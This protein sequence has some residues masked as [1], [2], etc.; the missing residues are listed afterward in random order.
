MRRWAVLAGVCALSIG[1]IGVAEPVSATPATAPTPGSAGIGDPYFPDAG[2]GGYDVKHYSLKLSYAAKHLSGKATIIAAATQALSRFDLD[3]RPDM[4]ASSVSVD[5]LPAKFGHK[6]Q[7]LIVTPRRSLRRYEPFV[8]TVKYAGKP[9]PVIDPDGALDGWIPTDD[10][11]V[12]ASEPQ[13]S[14]TWFP[15]NDHPLD[16]ATYDIS[17]TVPAGLTVIGNGRLAGKATRHGRSTFVWVENRPMATYLVTATFGHFQVKTGRTKDGIPIITAVDP[18]EAKDANPALAK[19][20]KMIAFEEKIFGPYPFDTVGAIVDD[21]PQVGYA[22]ETQTKPVFDGAPDDSLLLHEL[23]HQWY[24]D[25]VALTKWQDIW[26]NE[27]FATMAE[28]LWAEHTTGVTTQETFDGFYAEPASST[29][30]WNPPSGDPKDGADIFD[31]SVY[32]RGAMTLQAFRA[33]AGDKAFFRTLRDWATQHRNG[34]GTTAQFVALANHN[35]GRNLDKLFNVWL[36]QK[37]KPKSW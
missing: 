20:P 28:W 1:V 21:A 15:C 31:T 11:A 10:G 30:L 17:F 14:P 18:R 26:L 35:S 4:K 29:E 22:L 36:F 7:E 19:L 27:G 24:G 13:G 37:G 5:G 33:R 6:G 32:L 16:K 3:L 12:L 25:S 9:A 8:V 23:A 2:N 34:H